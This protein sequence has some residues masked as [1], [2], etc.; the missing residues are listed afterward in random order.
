MCEF[1]KIFLLYGNIILDCFFNLK[2]LP[3]ITIFYNHGLLTYIFTQFD[4]Y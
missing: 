1:N 4:Y 3:N 2:Q